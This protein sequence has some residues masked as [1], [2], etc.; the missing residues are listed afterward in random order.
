MPH[1]II[2]QTDDV[3]INIILTKMLV[4]GFGDIPFAGLL[5]MDDDLGFRADFTTGATTR[6]QEVSDS[7]PVLITCR[8]EFS[9]RPQQTVGDLVTHL[10][11]IGGHS[12]LLHGL[13]HTTGIGIHTISE[14]LS[15]GLLPGMRDELLPW[16]CPGVTVVE[17]EHQLHTGFLHLSAQFDDIG[18]ILADTLVL[19]TVWC[20]GGIYEEAHTDGIPALLLDEW[21]ETDL[22]TIEVLIDCVLCFV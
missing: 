6:L 9:S 12:G 19:M 17:V 8:I 13:Q 16:V 1:R 21:Q 14:R 22:P 18:Q 20:V 5:R 7:V 3:V 15:V 10:Y 4:V 11:H 2:T